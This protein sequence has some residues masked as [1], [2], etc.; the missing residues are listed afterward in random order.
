MGRHGSGRALDAATVSTCLKVLSRVQSNVTSAEATSVARLT[1]WLGA[2]VETV[3]ARQS[4][5]LEALDDP[6]AMELLLPDSCFMRDMSTDNTHTSSMRSRRASLLPD[7]ELMCELSIN[8]FSR[9]HPSLQQ[10]LD[11]ILDWNRFDVFA[12]ERLSK[13]RPLQTVTWALLHHF[14]LVDALDISPD[15]LRRYLKSVEA[16]YNHNPY[17]NSQHAAD[18]TQNVGVLLADAIH[19]QLG[20]L[21]I[22]A[23]ILAACVH[24]ILHPG[25]GN[26]YMVNTATDA[27]VTYNDNSVNENMHAAEAFRLMRREGHDFLAHLP[28]DQWRFVRHTMVAIILATD[29]AVHA[30]LV[31]EF[32]ADVAVL[33]DDVSTWPQGKRTVALTM[34]VHCA[35]LGNPGKP[36]HMS[37]NWSARVANEFFAQGDAERAANLP[38]SRLCD[39]EHTDICA[40]QLAFMSA[41][42][43]PSFTA[44]SALTPATSRLA[45]NNVAAN[46]EHWRSGK[47]P[48]RE[49]LSSSYTFELQ[50]KALD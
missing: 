50:P 22:L 17:H 33:G 36:L 7:S 45:L 12:V 38:I 3:D 2:F 41:I 49:W 4:T 46:Q 43:A 14:E 27:S 42:V 32:T 11:Q 48:W 6:R 40:T 8:S 28:P 24:D 29:M 10:K 1:R 13:G 19:S 21:E 16:L 5:E 31:A 25:F 18:V 39:R 23:C 44:L 30:D 37:L 9:P 34:L 47:V 35:D 15:K 26:A 20:Q